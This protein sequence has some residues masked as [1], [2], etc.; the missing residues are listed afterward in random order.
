MRRKVFSFV[1][2]VMLTVMAVPGGH[3][4]DTECGYDAVND[5]DCIYEISLF[6]WD[7]C[8]D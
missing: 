7:H 3:V 5:S 2:A 8:G 1:F 6:G 4:H